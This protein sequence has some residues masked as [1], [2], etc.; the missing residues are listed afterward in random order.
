MDP[1]TEKELIDCLRAMSS[2]LNNIDTRL[3]ELTNAVREIAGVETGEVDEN[4]KQDGNPGED[5]A[6]E[7]DGEEIVEIRV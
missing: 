3:E 1:F 7:D 5:E 6:D 4:F 2:T